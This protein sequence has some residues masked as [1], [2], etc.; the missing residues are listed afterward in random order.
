MEVL[1]PPTFDDKLIIPDKS[2]LSINNRHLPVSVR[3]ADKICEGNCT[4]RVCHYL[5]KDECMGS[6]SH[7]NVCGGANHYSTGKPKA[8]IYSTIHK[9]M[10]ADYCSTAY[11]VGG[12]FNDTDKLVTISIISEPLNRL[13]ETEYC[14]IQNKEQY[15]QFMLDEYPTNI[16]DI[17]EFLNQKLP[18]YNNELRYRIISKK[19]FL[20]RAFGNTKVESRVFNELLSVDASVLRKLVLSQFDELNIKIYRCDIVERPKLM[21]LFHTKLVKPIA[22]RDEELI[23]KVIST[24]S[25]NK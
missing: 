24:M 10:T 13:P 12:G 1:L 7:A 14:I 20:I 15:S 5:V 16:S 4:T 22:N 11:S 9:E 3:L 17:A 2:L 25:T 18:D 8:A 21:K 19:V 6:F 23:R